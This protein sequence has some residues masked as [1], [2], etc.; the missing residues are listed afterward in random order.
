[1]CAHK[2]FDRFIRIVYD[3]TICKLSS[4][5]DCM[6]NIKLKNNFVET[7]RQFIIAEFSIRKLGSSSAH[8]TSGSKALR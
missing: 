8:R 4:L 6:V 1:M 5:Y 3:L 7:P 2:Q